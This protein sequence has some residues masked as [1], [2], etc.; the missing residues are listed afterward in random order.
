MALPDGRS[1][2]YTEFGDPRGAPVFNCHGGLTSRLDVRWLDGVARGVGV[3]LIS[4]DR[5]GVGR[6]DRR[7]GRSLLDWP[8]DVAALADSLD[9]DRFAVSGWSAGGPYAAACAY[10]LADR[11]TA[12][13]LVASAIPYPEM[14]G[15]LHLV[16]RLFFVLAE[17]AR[18]A[19]TG[20]CHGIRACARV[21]PVGFRAGSLI[22]LDRAS[23][24]VV[25]SIS[26]ADYSEPI[27]EGLR[28]PAGVLDDY[29][30]LA[31][32][33]GFDLREITCPAHILQGDRDGFVPYHWAEWLAGEIPSSELTTC[34]GEGHFLRE[35]RYQR[36]L[37]TLAA[38]S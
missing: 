6:S 10:A 34:H 33:W 23:R 30:V 7:V 31:E 36:A 1:L 4:P 16:D 14:S 17:R 26:A 27:A 8:S 32:P 22:T 29:R 21:S 38:P 9:V 2:G 18:W 25:M 35:D 37:Q 24:R 13:A 12:L 28:N 3:R 5:P 19:A 20:L 11:V 15:G